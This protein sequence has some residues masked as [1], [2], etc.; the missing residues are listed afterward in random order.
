[1]DDVLRVITE[2]NELVWR[3]LKDSVA[4]LSDD[5][6]DWRPHPLGNNI[7]VIVRHL[8]I[9]AQWHLDSLTRGDK[10]PTDV[11]PALQKSIDGV[12]LDFRQNFEKLEELY[13]GFLEALRTTT[14]QGLQDR[15]VAAYGNTR[16]AARGLAHLL[17]Y[18]Q[19]LHV[20]GHCGQICTIRN[21]YRKARGEPARFFPENPTYPR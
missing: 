13:T 21:L 9:E 18:H 8:R 11:S 15:T 16:A 20:T 4:N 10:M 6:I 3:A 12:P 19:A 7:N 5:E 14:L 2:I 17:A 1:M